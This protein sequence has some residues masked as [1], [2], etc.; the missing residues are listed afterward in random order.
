LVNLGTDEP[1]GEGQQ[2]QALSPY[3]LVFIEEYRGQFKGKTSGSVAFTEYQYEHKPM[4]PS[5]YAFC[6]VRVGDTGADD[7]VVTEIVYAHRRL[8]GGVDRAR[9]LMRAKGWPVR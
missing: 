4:T 1:G 5:V 2:R 9:E 8:A 3:A 6:V 7:G